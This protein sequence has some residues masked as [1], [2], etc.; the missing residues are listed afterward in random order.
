MG[1]SLNGTFFIFRLL[2]GKGSG[3]EG[4]RSWGEGFGGGG[5]G[6]EGLC[7]VGLLIGEEESSFL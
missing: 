5:L 6:G 4:R 3:G 7:G 1:Y 2:E